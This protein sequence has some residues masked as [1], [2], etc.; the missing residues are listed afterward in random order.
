MDK[1][2]RAVIT[3]EVYLALSTNKRVLAAWG[4]IREALGESRPTVR[5]KLPAQQAKV[6]ICP[7]NKRGTYRICKQCPGIKG[8]EFCKV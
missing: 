2:S 7:L 8:M 4:T 1:L 5:S 3:I 6:K